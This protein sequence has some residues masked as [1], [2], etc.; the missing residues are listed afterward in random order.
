MTAVSPAPSTREV[1][2]PGAAPDSGTGK[3]KGLWGW[4]GRHR[5]LAA[6]WALVGAA[7]A[8]VL[9]AQLAPKGDA[10]PLS[11]NNAGPDGARAVTQ[12]LGRHGVKV[13]G[14]GNF[15]AAMAALEAGTSPTLL[16]Y[17]RSGFLDEPRLQE[18]AASAE[19]VVLVSPRLQTLAALSG[20]I[21]QAGVVPDASS[22]LDPGCSLPDAEAAG[23]V[24]GESGFI[25]DGGTSCYRP[26][27]SAA[28]VLAVEGH[29]RLTVLGS[30]GILNNG[31]L[32]DLGHAAL[33][34]RTLGTSPDLVWYLPTIED[35]ETGASP[36]TLDELA[37]DWVRFLGPW[38]ALVAA[39]AIA[40]R[41]R[42][43]GPLVF[44]PLPVVV[45]AVETA[46]GRAR[47][48]HDSRA[49]DQ[50]RD[51]LRAGT[52]VRLSGHLRV[53]AA[54]TADQVVNA[55]ARHLGQPARQIHELV[56]EHPRTEARLVAWSRELDNLEKEVKRR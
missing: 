24:S 15:E 49:V 44:E 3:A 55:A 47:L 56:N 19:R 13:H 52:L 43:L 42:R 27:G 21:R 17:D 38:L 29:G 11:L 18:L 40:W 53:G 22:A 12:I 30:T 7:L 20:S 36:Q 50:A 31:R 9:W 26:A 39:A 54:A 34:I 16:L 33:A 25:Y 51:N 46:E 41:G 23:P 14:V 45:K 4:L 28:G 35:L 6:L 8:L 5:A 32:D 10:V 1:P 2:E 37:P 48:Y